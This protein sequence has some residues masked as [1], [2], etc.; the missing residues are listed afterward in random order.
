MK[1]TRRFGHSPFGNELLLELAKKTIEAENLGS[2]AIPD[3]L[4]L[5]FSAT[6]AIGHSWGPDSPE[7]L[8]AMLRADR[9]VA[10]LLGQ[11]DARVGPGRYLVV[12]TS[13][14]GV[15]PLPEVARAH[16]QDAGRVRPSSFLAFRQ[17]RKSGPATLRC[18]P[19]ES[20][21]RS[22]VRLWSGSFLSFR[23]AITRIL[24]LS[25]GGS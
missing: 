5:S 24:F 1:N 3:L 25:L 7:M 19:G 6:D 2:G 23:R 14:H 11:L 12:L 9:L 17:R 16:G 22:L 20:L 21:A 15:C 10:D 8:D 4:C 13:D 18:R